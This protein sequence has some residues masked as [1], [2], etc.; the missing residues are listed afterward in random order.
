MSANG[1]SFCRSS[2]GGM[3]EVTRVK[4]PFDDFDVDGTFS[5]PSAVVDRKPRKAC[6]GWPGWKS[7]HVEVVV[8]TEAQRPSTT[9]TI[10]GTDSRPGTGCGSL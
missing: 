5:P 8:S 9:A 7:G 2:A 4:N 3:A 10:G 1:T 6:W